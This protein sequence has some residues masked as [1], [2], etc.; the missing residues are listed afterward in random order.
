[1]SPR[2]DLCATAL[3]QKIKEIFAEIEDHRPNE[4]DISLEDILGSAF[5]MFSLKDDSLLRFDKRREDGEERGNLERVYGIEEIPCDTTMRE[6]ID[7]V[8]P[9]EIKKGFKEIFKEVQRGGLLKGFSYI[10]GHYLV[11]LDGTQSFKSKNISCPS[12]LERKQRNGKVTY[13]HQFMVAVIV[14]PDRSEVI[15]IGVEPI[16]KQDGETKNDCERNAGKRLIES[17]RK[18]HPRLKIIVLEDG[19]HSTGPN[20]KEIEKREMGYVIGA[21]KSDHK[22]LFEEL[23][24]RK[25]AGQSH[26]HK[27]IEEETGIEHHFHYSNDLAINASN[28]D[29]RVNI[30]EYWEKSEK[31]EQYFAW[32]T[33]IEIS[34]E[35]VKEIM[36]AGRA[37][38]KVEN[39]TL[40]TLKNQGYNAEHNYGHGQKNLAVNLMV[41]MML[42]FLVDQVLQIAC[43]VF[44]GAKAKC[45][46]KKLLWERVRHLFYTLPFECMEDIYRAITHGF[47]VTG[48]EILYDTS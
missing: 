2:K 5:A 22:K 17:I 12:C 16:I 48:Y 29:V 47:K 39:E 20:L 32:V 18:E 21:K 11:S 36:E 25:E 9:E 24:K 35:N 33:D 23:E 7:E 13:S 46:S 40:N 43:P 42:A 41:I 6:V 31:K 28:E 3:Y 34:E 10:D 4:V 27:T 1:M 44:Q 19:L 15:P 37:R 45:K 38:W 30:L 14:H 26:N 8:D